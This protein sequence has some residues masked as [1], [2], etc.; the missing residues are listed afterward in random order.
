MILLNNFAVERANFTGIEIGILQ[1]IREIPGFLA[2]TVV[3]VLLI[4]KEQSLSIIA[5]AIMGLGVSIAG[6]FPTIYG[7]YFT[8]IVMSTGFHYFET[9][10]NSL[11][12]QWLS[13][14]EAPQVL[15][16]LIAVGSITSLILYCFIW[17]F[18]K[19]FVFIISFLR[20]N[21]SSK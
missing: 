6:Y 5:L 13:K 9:I 10:K 1:S 15:G 16:K 11:S 12:L 21:F 4:I 2:F 17:L 7:L 19:I 18:L 14:E 3:F 8:T 20:S